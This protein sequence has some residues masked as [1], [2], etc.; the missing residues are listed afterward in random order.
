MLEGDI[1]YNRGKIIAFLWIVLSFLSSPLLIAFAK[2]LEYKV[3]PVTICILMQCIVM[4]Y[5]A[6][7][8]N[9]ILTE[10]YCKKIL[11]ARSIEGK[12]NSFHIFWMMIC[13]FF[14]ILFSFSVLMEGK[15]INSLQLVILGLLFPGNIMLSEHDLIL[16]G[17]IIPRKDIVSYE[18]RIESN[19]K[20]VL[21]LIVRFYTKR[22]GNSI[23]KDKKMV[24]IKNAGIIDTIYLWLEGSK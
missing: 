16:Y 24:I 23:A 15:L 19:N 22:S 6:Y 11:G 10:I 8:L 18:M 14:F 1:R 17:N 20:K 5:F 12:F 3:I 21:E 13:I 7:I 4:L 9:T 2:S